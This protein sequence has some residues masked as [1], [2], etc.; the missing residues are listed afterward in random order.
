MRQP[1]PTDFSFFNKISFLFGVST[2][3]VDMLESVKFKI[4]EIRCHKQLNQISECI[5]PSNK[6]TNSDNSICHKQ[7]IIQSGISTYIH[8]FTDLHPGCEYN[9]SARVY[10]KVYDKELTSEEVV[11][12]GF[13]SLIIIRNKNLEKD[14]IFKI[15]SQN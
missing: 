4:N 7:P 12:A 15:F 8:T 14:L 2:S 13:T 6:N 5:F 11:V 1:Q 10:S 9:M 3:I